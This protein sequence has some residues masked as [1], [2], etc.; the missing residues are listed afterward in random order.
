M[1]TGV[2]TLGNIL[3]FLFKILLEDLSNDWNSMSA[4]RFFMCVHVYKWRLRL[5]QNVFLKSHTTKT[6]Q[7]NWNQ[8]ASLYSKTW[9]AGAAASEEF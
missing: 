3:Q 1:D 4:C 5:E 8:T 6:K 2:I 9:E 7:L